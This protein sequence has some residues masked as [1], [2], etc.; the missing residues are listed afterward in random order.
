MT[1]LSLP[2]FPRFNV[3]SE[4]G[5]GYNADLDHTGYWYR[6]LGYLSLWYEYSTQ[7][8]HRHEEYDGN[9]QQAVLAG[10]CGQL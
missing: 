6:P 9:A 3:N 10:E 5:H 4:L 2:S 7:Q 1:H 8:Q